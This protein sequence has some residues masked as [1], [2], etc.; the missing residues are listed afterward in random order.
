MGKEGR[1]GEETTLPKCCTN[2]PTFRHGNVVNTGEKL[3]AIE[4]TVTS[5]EVFL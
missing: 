3:I 2:Q 5:K 4:L 1:P